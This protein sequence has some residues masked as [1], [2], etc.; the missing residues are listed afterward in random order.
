MRTSR[1]RLKLQQAQS[2]DRLARRCRTAAGPSRLALCTTGAAGLRCAFRKSCPHIMVVQPS[3]DW[4]S[5]NDPG[6]LHCPT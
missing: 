2:H 3:Q 6:P 4:D 5:Y 1:V